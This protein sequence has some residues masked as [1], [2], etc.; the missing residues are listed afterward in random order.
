MHHRSPLTSTRPSR[1]LT[2]PAGPGTGAMDED[3]VARFCAHWE[4]GD[5]LT[6]KHSDARF[7][8]RARLPGITSRNCRAARR[9]AAVAESHAPARSPA[10]AS[11]REKID[12]PCR[13]EQRRVRRRDSRRASTPTS[14]TGAARSW[15]PAGSLI[16]GLPKGLL[17]VVSSRVTDARGAPRADPRIGRSSGCESS[18]RAARSSCAYTG[19][20]H[21]G[22]RRLEWN[23]GPVGASCAA[24]C[25]CGLPPNNT[26]DGLRMATGPGRGSG[27]HGEAW[28]CRSRIPGD[29]IDGK[30]REPQRA[31][32][33]TRPRSIIVNRRPV[34]FVNEACD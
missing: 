9:S 27:Q 25:G 31:L 16:A 18:C 12:V 21:P 10:S 17:T 19:Q 6:E 5:R 1:T 15:W 33:R 23:G 24:R 11:G 22:H 7:E 13:L 34:R 28:W 14:T 3:L 20:C 26:G 8:D 32:E 30:P 2:Y 29:T 4:S